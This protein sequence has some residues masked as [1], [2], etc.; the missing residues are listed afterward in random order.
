[1]LL[2]NRQL[3]RPRDRSHLERFTASHE[4]FYR[5]VEASSVTPSPGPPS[6]AAWRAL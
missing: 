3:I 1:M 4:S 5:H 2:K 6:T